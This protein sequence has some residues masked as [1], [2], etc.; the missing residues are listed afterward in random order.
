MGNIFLGIVNQS[1]VAGWLVIAVIILRAILQKINAPRSIICLMWVFVAARLVLPI[2]IESGLSLIPSAKPLP[3]DFIYM[4]KPYID[5]G[6]ASVDRVADSVLS[7]S[8]GDNDVMA[9]ANRTQIWAFVLSCVWCGGGVIMLIYAVVSALFLRHRLATAT[10]LQK[11]VKQSEKVTSPFVLGVFKPVVYLPYN[12]VAADLPYVLAHERAHIKRRD[13]LWKIIGFVLLGVYWFNPLMWAAY[14]LFCRDI[15]AACDERVIREMQK[16][17][18]RAYSTALLNSSVKRRRI[19]AC[20]IAFGENGVKSRVRSIMNY[21]KP[22]FWIVLAS[23]AACVVLVV[24]FMTNPVGKNINIKGTAAER[25]FDSLDGDEYPLAN[26]KE[27]ALAEYEGVVFRCDSDKLE[28]VYD[29]GTDILFTGMP[30]W[31]VYFS[32]VTGDG[33]P[34][35]CATISV[36]SGII[37]ERVMVY[38]FADGSLYEL[39]DREKYDYELYLQDNLL[40]VRKSEYDV[41]GDDGKAVE[42]KPLSA[43]TDELKRLEQ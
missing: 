7:A 15:E 1:L 39:S 25:W 18:R 40:Y 2:S 17:E 9:T 26:V 33:K 43:Y 6:M 19:G 20:P 4:D 23:V 13:Y 11:G 14:I 3:D 34:D 30:I 31:N 38:D 35:I 8:L 29:D 41:S 42:N 37:D 21:R 5:S 36:G 24:C 16:D 10:L 27:T 12:L 28:A 32:D 22:A